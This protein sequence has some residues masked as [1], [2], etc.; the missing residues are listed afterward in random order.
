M[1][2]RSEHFLGF[3]YLKTTL[4]EI[5]RSSLVT[6]LCMAYLMSRKYTIVEAQIKSL[7]F[8]CYLYSAGLVIRGILVCFG[9][10][11]WEMQVKGA[12]HKKIP[13]ANSEF[14]TSNIFRNAPTCCAFQDPLLHLENCSVFQTIICKA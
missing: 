9:F 4:K 6:A 2:S 13:I 11:K 10:S 8:Y 7:Q 3:L 14:V 1:T 5:S 12:F